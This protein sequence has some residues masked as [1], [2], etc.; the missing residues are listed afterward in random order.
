MN[1]ENSRKIIHDELYKDI[2]IPR[3]SVEA[4]IHCKD[5]SDV[6]ILNKVTR[7]E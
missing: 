5:T 7:N 6:I 3:A 1:D 4:I 2:K